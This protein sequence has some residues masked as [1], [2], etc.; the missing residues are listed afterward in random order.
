VVVA[1]MWLWPPSRARRAGAPAEAGEH[2]RGGGDG[3]TGAADSTRGRAGSKSASA[4][5]A[6]VV[7]SLLRPP[8]LLGARGRWLT[9]SLATADYKRIEDRAVD[10]ALALQDRCGL[11]AVTDGEMRRMFFTGVVTDA[12]EGVGLTPGQT[13]RWHGNGDEDETLDIQLPV[14]VTGQCGGGR[15]PPRSSPMPAD[16]RIACSRSRSQ[17]PD[18]Q[19]LLVTREITLSLPRP[20][21]TL[22]RR[23]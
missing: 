7:G 20:V 12:I 23:G 5:R 22:R 14:A 4:S 9:G 3:V 16:A 18:A 8:E 1:M 17:S 13:T 10:A 19:L 15:W 21:R 2:G 6:D 11:D